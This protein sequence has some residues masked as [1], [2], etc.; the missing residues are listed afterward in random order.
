MP[1]LNVSVPHKLSE[2]EATNRIRNLLGDLKT[3]FGN[4]IKNLQ[5]S[6]T[7]NAAQFS[8]EVMGFNISGTLSIQPFQVSL[9][10]QMPM[11][12]LPFKSKIEDVIRE[13]I[14]VL[15]L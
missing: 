4:R 12:A 14:T 2:S 10:G 9:T 15:L 11:A 3:Q 7:Q 6:W 1:S 5:E 8:V 13:R